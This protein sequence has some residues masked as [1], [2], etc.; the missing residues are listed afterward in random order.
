MNKDRILK[1]LEVVRAVLVS[2]FFLFLLLFAVAVVQL[3][4][5]FAYLLIAV[6]CGVVADYTDKIIWLNS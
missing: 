5:P 3:A 1:V 4:N 2:L 6:I